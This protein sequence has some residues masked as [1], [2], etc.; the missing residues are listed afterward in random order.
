MDKFKATFEKKADGKIKEQKPSTST[1]RSDRRG[2]K[3]IIII[4]S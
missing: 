3:F 1:P 2:G 4:F